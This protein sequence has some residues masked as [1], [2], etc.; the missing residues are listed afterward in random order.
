MNSDPATI[1]ANNFVISCYPV[2]PADFVN[3]R[4]D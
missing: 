4:E 2:N 1:D 3:P